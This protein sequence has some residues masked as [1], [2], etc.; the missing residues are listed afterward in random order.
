MN[1]IDYAYSVAHIRAIENSL[2]TKSDY[3]SLLTSSY[4]DALRLLSEKGYN[5]DAGKTDDILEEK[6]TGA[7]QLLLSSA[8]DR[9]L[10]DILLYENDFENL[11]TVLKGIFTDS[12]F[13]K[14]LLLKPT[15]SDWAKNNRLIA[16]KNFS[17]LPDEFKKCTDDA[18]EILARSLDSDRADAIVDSECMTLMYRLAKESGNAFILNVVMLKNTLKNIKIAYR[19]AVSGKGA[20]FLEQA[21]SEHAYINKNTL[22][23]AALDGTDAIYELLSNEGYSDAGNFIKESYASFEVFADNKISETVKNSIYTSFGVEPLIAY[24]FKVMTEVKNIR[25]ILTAKANKIDEGEIRARMR[26]LV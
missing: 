10:L 2:L 15:V 9:S 4:E 8:P 5:N 26:S 25:I 6:L 19:S 12:E 13:Y 24:L 22:L 23:K 20:N 14:E 18:F 3:D 7:W 21:L 11:K 17:A 16:E 1:S